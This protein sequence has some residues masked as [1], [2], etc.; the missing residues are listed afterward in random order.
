M[1]DPLADAP[2]N[3]LLTEHRHLAQTHGLVTR[4]PADIAPFAVV[5]ENTPAA[6][7][8]LRTLLIPG[9]STWLFHDLPPTI[10]GLTHDNTINVLQMLYPRALPLPEA[11]GTATILPLNSSHAAEMVALTDVA[12][13]GFFR[14]RTH[15]MGH[16]F[17][18]R[19]ASGQLVAMGGE[20]LIVSTPTVVWREI[21]GL[22]THP[23]H[24]GHGY[25]AQLLRKLIEIQRT[26]NAISWLHVTSTNAN[27]IAL[28]RRLGFTDLREVT[29]H[30]VVRVN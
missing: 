1:L 20:R 12:F 9:E 10:P 4:Y 6:F 24:R 2:R 11:P 7:E 16:Y 23:D 8:D 19:D 22:C 27:A 14:T 15:V 25:A 21:S 18:I 26:L 3:A 17:G 29:I 5:F 28:Y 30:R 13:P